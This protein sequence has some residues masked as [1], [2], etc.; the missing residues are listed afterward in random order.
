MVPQ[1]LLEGFEQVN[2]V[3][4]T[5]FPDALIYQGAVSGDITMDELK[6]IIDSIY[7]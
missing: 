4:D 3:V 2:L 6:Q 7:E 1:W 5:G